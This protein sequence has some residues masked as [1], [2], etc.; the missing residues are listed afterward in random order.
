MV[1][2]YIVEPHVDDAYLSLHAHITRW[3]AGGDEVVIASVFSGTRSRINDAKAYTAEV[4]AKHVAYGFD[5]N[6]SK[7]EP[8]EK[9]FTFLSPNG[10]PRADYLLYVPAGT[11][12]PVHVATRRWIS[13]DFIYFD[14]PYIYKDRNR[15]ELH[16]L[17]SNTKISSICPDSLTFKEWFWRC[18]PDQ[19]GFFGRVSPS[20]YIRK[21]E[22]I[23][24]P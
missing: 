15:R 12:H 20:T 6:R 13:P 1:R 23:I 17:S 7:T 16:A 2:R 14:I 9:P 5:E 4:G 21:R 10:R 11:E 22:T 8:F 24:A 3:V 19:L 18:F